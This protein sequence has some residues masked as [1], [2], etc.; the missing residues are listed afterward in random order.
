MAIL[1]NPSVLSRQHIP[2]RL[3]HRES[4]LDMLQTLLRD[5]VE[6][7]PF[8][9]V[10]QLIGPKGTGKT[11]SSHL[12]LKSLRE[13]NP[14]IQH[15]Y[16]NLRALADISPWVF[17]S[18]LL[19]KMGGKASRSLSAGEL[20]DKFVS[21]L[22]KEKGKTFI[23]TIDEA[24]QLSGYRSLRGGQIVYNLTRLSELGVENV[25]GVIFISRDESWSQRLAPEEQSSL[26][27]MIVNYPA[28]T[29]DQLVDIILY[30]A[31][32]AF[33]IGTFPEAVA[34]YLAEVTVTL[35]DSDLRKALDIL[36]IAAQ[37][38]ETSKDE[39]LSYNHINRAIEQGLREKYLFSINPETL[40]TAERVVLSAILLASRQLNQSFITLR[41]IQRY[42]ELICEN[43]RLRKLTPRETDEA[44]QRLT[45]EGYIQFKGPLRV[46]ITMLPP[47]A[48]QEGLPDLVEK[49]LGVSA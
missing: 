43:Y 48:R 39:K 10:I 2:S 33:V 28:Y 32:E 4:Q 16:V 25:S 7:P 18:Q 1:R 45:D 38:A 8:F 35:F 17:Y 19:T 37:I 29:R 9:K 11:T 36:L 5:A 40:G 44:L 30:R 15:V 23:L 46:Y 20:F 27:N 26:G 22:R 14:L 49:L 42:I 24:D 13:E 47:P 21:S 12:L 31:S 6:G 34:E 3:P 41:D